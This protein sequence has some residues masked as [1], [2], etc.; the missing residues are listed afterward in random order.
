MDYFDVGFNV[1]N[2]SFPSS[3]RSWT[4]LT[5]L[6]LEENHFIGGIPDFLSEFNNLLELKIGGNLFK[7][8]IPKSIGALHN[9]IYGLNLSANGLTGEIPLEIG[10]LIKLQ[11]LDV[12]LN[13]LTGSID[14]LGE[15]LSLIEVN[16]SYNN[17]NGSVPKNLMKLLNSSP[18]SFLGNSHI[19]INC[20]P[21]DGLNCTKASHL[22]PCSNEFI[23]H[24]HKRISK[25]V[26]VMIEVGSSMFVSAMLVVLVHMNLQKRYKQ[27]VNASVEGEGPLASSFIIIGRGANQ[28]IGQINKQEVMIRTE[29]HLSSLVKQVMKVTNNL[30]DQHIVGRGAHGIV[31]KVQLGPDQALA[32]KKISFSTNRGKSKHK[33]KETMVRE[34][35]ISGMIDHPNLASYT[36]YWFGKDYGVILYKYMEN[37]SLHDVLHD[38]RN[39]PPSLKWNVR[40]NIAIGAAN[41]LAYL[42]Y[43]CRPPIVHRDIKPKNIL[44]DHNLEPVITDFGTSLRR[45]WHEHSIFPENR[46]RLSAYIAGTIGY[47]APENAYAIVV[48]RKSDVYSYGVVLLELITRKKVL[49]QSF[50]EEGTSLVRWIRS[51]YTE[52][53]KIGEIVDSSL[54]GEF[55][56]SIII[57]KQVSAV[58]DLALRCTQRDPRK[59]P[60]I[61]KVVRFFQNPIFLKQRH[62]YDDE[63]PHPQAQVEPSKISDSYSTNPTN[64]ISN[65]KVA[66]K[67]EVSN[68]WQTT[69][70]LEVKNNQHKSH[71]AWRFPPEGWV[72]VNIHS[73]ATGGICGGIMRGD[74]GEWLQG[75]TVRFAAYNESDDVVAGIWGIYHGMK[76]A[77][78]FGFPRVI[79]ETDNLTAVQLLLYV[80]TNKKDWEVKVQYIFR[81]GNLC[82]NWLVNSVDYWGEDVILKT[83]PKELVD[84]LNQ[85]VFDASTPMA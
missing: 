56:Q 81:E 18:S 53:Q 22:E 61:R 43:N 44:L 34:V 72:K 60:T 82:A 3:L 51:V 63:A 46:Q 15:L 64:S 70:S 2:G 74:S 29:K 62:E 47:I 26:I 17:F 16:I 20:S 52:P 9:L 42:H 77:W 4:G 30:N 13:N 1:I 75:F 80:P 68:F 66:S 10:K 6:I 71:I 67:E 27:E 54:A 19:C 12:S 7:G 39:P 76:M 50:M 32:A 58:L 5:T 23:D 73:N 48:S 49:D 25:L 37:G 11:S 83:P 40:L 85:D 21:L 14:V 45:R 78:E 69:N 38:E 55:S 36:D 33:L 79:I 35:Q 65:S 24:N 59:R 28:H 84:I 31:Y 41:G 8:E 57:M